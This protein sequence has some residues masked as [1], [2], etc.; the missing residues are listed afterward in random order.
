MSTYYRKEELGDPY[1]MQRL[2]LLWEM[3]PDGT[4]V[5]RDSDDPG[6]LTARINK[7]PG[8]R[9]HLK[10]EIGLLKIETARNVSNIEMKEFEGGTARLLVG[11][12][13][14]LNDPTLVVE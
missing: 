10:P 6:K 7:S 1:A 8:S 2:D 5:P 12:A 11:G 13:I 14:Q 3:L 9:E 4:G